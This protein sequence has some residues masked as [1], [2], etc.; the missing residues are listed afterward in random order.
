MLFRSCTTPEH[1][2]VLSYDSTFGEM[3]VEYYLMQ[4]DNFFKRIYVALKYIFKCKSH[5]SHFDC[6]ILTSSQLKLLR[7]YLT[8]IDSVDSHE[9][10]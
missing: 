7:Q 8:S 2:I 5:D 3:Y 1:K 10:I 4:Y 6:T 9:D